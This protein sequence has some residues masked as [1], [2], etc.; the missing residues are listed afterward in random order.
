MGRE[1]VHFSSLLPN[2]HL[3]IILYDVLHIPYLDANLISLGALHWQGMSVQS[4]DNSLV[5]SKNSKELFRA[6]LTGATGTLY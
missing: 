2:S 6:S 5:L 3:N 1:S 4:I